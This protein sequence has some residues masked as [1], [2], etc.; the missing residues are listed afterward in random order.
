MGEIDTHE[1]SCNAW[2]NKQPKV[3]QPDLNYIGELWNVWDTVPYSQWNIL[4]HYNHT[5]Y[6]NHVLI[7]APETQHK[8]VCSVSSDMFSLGMLMVS[9]FNSGQSLIQ[10]NH[11]VNAFFKQAGT[12]CVKLQ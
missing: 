3:V 2:T 10:A 1:I 12:V 4:Q 6:L 8:S 7:A 11:S 5:S 9:I